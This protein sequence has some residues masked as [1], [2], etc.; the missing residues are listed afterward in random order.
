MSGES[1]PALRRHE[2]A[3]LSRWKWMKIDA[4]SSIRDYVRVGFVQQMSWI[5]V[6]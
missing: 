2:Q 4:M 3:I 6:S 5:I 1:S